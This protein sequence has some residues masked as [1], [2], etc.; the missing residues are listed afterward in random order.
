MLIVYQMLKELCGK[1]G[2]AILETKLPVYYKCSKKDC[3][4]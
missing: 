3:E 2:L 4:N 1:L